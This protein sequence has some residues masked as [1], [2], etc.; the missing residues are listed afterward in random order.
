MDSPF[1][2]RVHS[3]HHSAARLRHSA[4]PEFAAIVR[5]GRRLAGSV[6]WA[7]VA[8]VVALCLAVAAVLHGPAEEAVPGSPSM[9]DVISAI[10]SVSE[11]FDRPDVPGYGRDCPGPCSFG[12]AWSDATE[13]PGGGNGCST[14]EDVLARDIRGAE[15]VP[16]EHCARTG[17]VLVD[18]YSGEELVLA[19]TYQSVHIDHVY[20]L[21]A[22][23]DM[24]AHAWPQEKRERFANDVDA[25]LLAVAGHANMAK[26]DALPSGWMPVEPWQCFYAWR[27]AVAASTYDLPLTSADLKQLRESARSCPD[28]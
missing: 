11:V 12:R 26:G 6:S 24:G 8:I 1:S 19:G 2:R 28:G 17:G 27:V 4:A 7:A 20:A 9:S 14:R 5:S 25:N 23:W 22:A 21:S 10:D 13:A 16:G 18:P 3:S 15:R